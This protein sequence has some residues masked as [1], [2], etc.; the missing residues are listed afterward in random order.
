MKTQT[1]F[2]VIIL[3]LGMFTYNAQAQW[4]HIYTNDEQ[5]RAIDVVT[6][7]TVYVVGL[8]C[9][10]RSLDGGETWETI[11]YNC[12]EYSFQDVEFVTPHVGY[13][14]GIGGI[15]LKSK[16]YGE[17]WQKIGPDSITDYGEAEF[18]TP[19]TGWIIGKSSETGRLVIRTYNGGNSWSYTYLDVSE[20]SD[21]QMLNSN[22][23]YIT[24]FN[25]FLK[26]VDG[27]DSWF[28]P[29]SIGTFY[30]PSTCCS[31]I[32]PD[33]GFIG[34]SGLYKTENGG[35]DWEYI[36]DQYWI[37][38]F[39]L[40]QMQFVNPDTGYYVGFDGVL[41]FGKLYTTIDGG[42]TWNG[43]QGNYINIDMYNKNI[44]YCIKWTGEVYKTTNGGLIT[45]IPENS[46]QSD[47][48][49]YPNPF[50]DKIFLNISGIPLQDELPG[51]FEVFDINGRKVYSFNLAA[52]K[53]MSLN[54]SRLKSGTYIFSLKSGNL[55]VK[56][57]KLIKVKE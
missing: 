57:G 53:N 31:F 6:P 14:V 5:I 23:G 36:T 27:G 49:L 40:G 2:T 9:A 35:A 20:L 15:I 10:I 32:N 33:T 34:A 29:D 37:G 24:H 38:Y 45:G 26:T 13:I 47:L 39:S 1:L 48:G 4:E 50:N 12:E 51:L 8:R 54:L 19:D 44:G 41:G 25:G 55:I 3:L 11:N 7:D 18:I 22:I 16:D 46:P 42:Q 28:D 43:S 21:I 17:N 56:S 52:Q 30:G